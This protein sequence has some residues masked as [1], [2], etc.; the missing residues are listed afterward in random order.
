MKRRRCILTIDSIVALF[1]DYLTEEDMPT[2]VVPI[3]LMVN[4]K[5][6]GK[7]A[8]LA[9]SLDWPQD[10]PPLQIHFDIR[11]IYGAI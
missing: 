10:A 3:K 2:T 1:K 4:P 7:L 9:E 8:I 11:R 6:V 5:E